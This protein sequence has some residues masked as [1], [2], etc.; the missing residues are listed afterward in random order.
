M[1]SAVTPDAP[2]PVA[3]IL[4]LLVALRICKPDQCNFVYNIRQ[5]FALAILALAYSGYAQAMRFESHFKSSFGNSKAF[6]LKKLK[7][8]LSPSPQWPQAALL[9]GGD[10]RQVP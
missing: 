8:S 2:R 10:G 4:T 5:Y 7:L 9:L 3:R 6:N 1:K